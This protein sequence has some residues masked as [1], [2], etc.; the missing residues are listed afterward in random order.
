[1]WGTWCDFLFQ[2]PL[3]A[4]TSRAERMC[5]V[6]GG[7]QSDNDHSAGDDRKVGIDFFFRS[8]A[9][10]AWLLVAAVRLTNDAPDWFPRGRLMEDSARL[11]EFG[12]LRISHEHLQ[13]LRSC[14][15]FTLC[16]SIC[17]SAAAS[18]CCGLFR[19]LSSCAILLVHQGTGEGATRVTGVA[20]GKRTSREP[21]VQV[22]RAGCNCGCQD[23]RIGRCVIWSQQDTWPGGRLMGSLPLSTLNPHRGSSI[24]ETQVG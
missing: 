22:S 10:V 6:P 8:S 24:V 2:H 21:D 1:M 4:G 15:L 3:N 14:L 23:S 16:P 11:S 20:C 19:A 17:I 7:V 9:F 12:E 5:Q 13:Q 18:G